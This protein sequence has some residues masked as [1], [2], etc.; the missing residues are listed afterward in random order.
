MMCEDG[1][2]LIKGFVQ[3]MRCI[4]DA[5]VSKNL[6]TLVLNGEKSVRRIA[7]AVLCGSMQRDAVQQLLFDEGWVKEYNYGTEKRQ[8][9]PISSNSF[10]RHRKMHKELQQGK[11]LPPVVHRSHVSVDKVIVLFQ[12]LQE[13]CTFKAGAT[14]TV[15]LKTGDIFR[16]MPV[17]QYSGD[18]MTLFKKYANEVTESVGSRMFMDCL[19]L[20][21]VPT[22]QQVGLSD[23]FTDWLR[24][25]EELRSLLELIDTIVEEENMTQ[26]QA[27]LDFVKDA[28]TKCV[29]YMKYS[30]KRELSTSN[31]NVYLCM[32]YA[33]CG[34]ACTDHEHSAPSGQAFDY[35]NL[36]PEM[37]RLLQ[38]VHDSFDTS[39]QNSILFKKLSNALSDI[40]VLGIHEWLRFPRH[41]MRTVCQNNAIDAVSDSL[42]DGGLLVVMDYKQ[43]ILPDSS[44]AAQA[45]WFARAGMSL[46]GCWLIYKRDSEQT[47]TFHF[48]DL[49][50]SNVHTQNAANLMV[51]LE[52]LLEYVKDMLPSINQVHI[53]SDNAANFSN[54]LL[55]PF[56]IV[57]NNTKKYPQVAT[58]IYTGKMLRTLSYFVD[59][60]CVEAGAGKTI[61]DCHFSYVSLVIQSRLKHRGKSVHVPRDIFDALEEKKLSQSS[62][63]LYK[64][65]LQLQESAI[66]SL[67]GLKYKCDIG[68]RCIHELRFKG[69]TKLLLF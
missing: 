46:L 2:G 15:R 36:M 3:S 64:H 55:Q 24:L 22:K 17:Y 27:Q 29:D 20:L 33:L 53:Q 50:P 40:Q 44:E 39:A 38:T 68:T 47:V 1:R 16:G 21:C 14:R 4:G 54:V 18:K 34:E 43:K 63:L 11:A 67:Q 51:A 23:R 69:K 45:D 60:S 19:R 32:R 26:L 57:M 37:I 13:V 59:K 5:K 61:L 28:L 7:T 58:W 56:I 65:D 25:V 35:F 42:Q 49:I 12:W 52:T 8:V 10:A 48:L 6:A 30:Y 41:I 62:A 66:A 9:T 31:S